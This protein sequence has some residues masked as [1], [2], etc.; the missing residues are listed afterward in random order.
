MLPLRRGI[1]WLSSFF[2]AITIFGSMNTLPSTVLAFWTNSIILEFLFGILIGLT[3]RSGWSLSPRA[4]LMLTATAFS[5]AIALGPLWGW[6]QVLPRFLSAGLP[7]AFLVAAAA[8]GPS[9]RATWLV[10][11]LVIVGDA[12]YSLY[13]THP[14]VIRPLRSIWIAVSGGSLPLGLYVVV[15]FLAATIAAIMINQLIEKPLTNALQRRAS[16]LSRPRANAI[17][18]PSSALA[19]RR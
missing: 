3:L 13:L 9:L 11:P 6:N 19:V 12:S 16:S 5:L 15:C 1:I 14:F 18:T 10:T 8:W 7:A 17:A 4:A 2:V